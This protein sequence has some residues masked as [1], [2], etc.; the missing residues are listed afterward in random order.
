MEQIEI[1]NNVPFWESTI[2]LVNNV[3]TEYNQEDF[4]DMNNKA[5][6]AEKKLVDDNLINRMQNDSDLF[7]EYNLISSLWNRGTIQDIIDPAI[8]NLSYTN[9]LSE[10]TVPSLIISGKH[11]MV[12][13]LSFS[14]EAFDNL[15]SNIKELVVFE[16]SGHSPIVS[17][18]DKFAEEVISFMN[19]NK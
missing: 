12:V 19:Q 15:G 3:T 4:F 9:R 1:G 11:D 16:R 18:A 8:R 2:D 5:F 6:E 17:E 10:I 13:P 14:Q 7:F